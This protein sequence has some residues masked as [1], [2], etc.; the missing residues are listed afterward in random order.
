MK[1]IEGLLLLV[2]IILLLVAVIFV[3]GENP[4]GLK[5]LDVWCL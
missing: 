5:C 1:K 2:L 3:L 4:A